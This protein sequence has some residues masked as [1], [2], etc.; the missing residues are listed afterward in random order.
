MTTMPIVFLDTETTSLR[1]DRRAWEVGMIRRDAEGE[2][3]INIFISDLDLS[4]ADLDALNVGRFFQRHPMYRHTS[5]AV[6][7]DSWDDARGSLASGEYLLPEWVTAVVVEQWTRG[8]CVVGNVPNFDT[9][10]LDVMLRRNQRRS[11]WHHQLGDFK[12]LAVGFLRG[13][14]AAGYASP[15]FRQEVLDVVSPPWNAD[16]LSRTCGVEPPS[17][18]ERHTALGDA[19]W[20]MRLYDQIMGGTSA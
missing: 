8:A 16:A 1:P 7:Y 17:A 20:A 4:G 3:E 14:V 2:R 9:E 15:A 11:T 18:D 5:Y 6:D 19:R 12:N 13:V 10:L